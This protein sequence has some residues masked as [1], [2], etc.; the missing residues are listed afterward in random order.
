MILR[1]MMLQPPGFWGTLNS[2][3]PK[4]WRTGVAFLAV[5]LALNLMTE[6][7]DVDRLG[8]TLWS[9]DNGLSLVL[10]IESVTFAPF[11]FL[12][13]VV[14]DIFVAGV[15]HSVYVIVTSE[16]LLVIVYVSLA[17]FVRKRLKFAPRPIRRADAVAFLIF[18]PAG[19]TLSSAVYCGILYLCGVFSSDKLFGVLRHFWI[20]DT[21]GMITIIPAI[22]S[23]FVTLSML[24]AL[25]IVY[26]EEIAE[27]TAYST[28]F[29][30][31]AALRIV[32][33][34]NTMFK[35]HSMELTSKLDNSIRTCDPLY[36][37]VHKYHISKHFS[38]RQRV[39][40]A[41]DHHK[42]EIQNYNSEY[43][44]QVYHSDGILL[45]E[46]VV[47]NLK[48][49]IVLIATDDNRHEGDLS[50]I[51]SVNNTRLSRMSFSYLNGNIFGLPS[52]MTLLISRNQS[53]RTLVRDLFDQC[54]KR[55]TPQLFCLAAVCGIAL[56]S[57]FKTML[58]IKHDSQ[59]AHEEKFDSGFR[60]SYTTLWERFG[61]VEIERH[62]YML[63]VPL[64][65]RPLRLVESS[66]RVRARNRRRYWDDISQSARSCIINH[67]IAS[68]S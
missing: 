67:R 29:R 52:Q 21:L 25:S 55:N 50:V 5:Y 53:D 12:G 56:S 19:A 68:K 46:R 33:F 7:S 44:R 61:G 11:V 1:D 63:N 58:A 37:L 20:G 43:A 18:I 42:Y 62:V 30:F 60:N 51:L 54:F 48:C 10:L 14:V 49:T 3:G 28:F 47:D 4:F 31:L 22:I 39:Q 23:V 32:L 13:A 34:P 36:F 35:F 59:I 66:H 57:E 41:M 38:L 2:A 8:I 65:L 24:K 9:P 6:W 16:F 64:D 40:A 45:W 26:H 27:G 15:R 17:L